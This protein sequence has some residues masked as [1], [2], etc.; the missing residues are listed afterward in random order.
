MKS[1]AE[2]L[3]DLAKAGYRVAEAQ[4]KVAHDAILLAMY[5]ESCGGS[6][7]HAVLQGG[8]GVA[9][10]ARPEAAPY[11][12][13]LEGGCPSQG[14]LRGTR[15][16]TVAV[17]DAINCVPPDTVPRGCSAFPVA[18]RIGLWYYTN[19]RQKQEKCRR[20]VKCYIHSQSAGNDSGRLIR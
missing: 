12:S 7:H 1:F 4:A 5:V 20:M 8:G 3:A 10:T 9:V 17:A 2:Q 19:R 6:P 13:R 14:R 16:P 18:G 15:D 11:Q